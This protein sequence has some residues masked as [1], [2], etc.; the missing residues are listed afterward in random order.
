MEMI[1]L[2]LDMASLS[3]PMV[4]EIIV[5]FLTANIDKVLILI[6]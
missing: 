2:S 1:T 6:A 3:I 4:G 5:S